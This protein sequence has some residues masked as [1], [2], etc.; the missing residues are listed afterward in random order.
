MMDTTGLTSPIHLR[1]VHYV[2]VTRQVRKPNGEQYENTDRDWSWLHNA[3][4]RAARWLGYVPFDRIV[5]ERNDAPIIRDAATR[6]DPKPTIWLAGAPDFSDFD[7]RKVGPRASLYEEPVSP[8]RYRLAMFGEKTSLDAVLGPLAEEYN[9]DL[10]LA[11]GEQT[12]SGVYGLARDAAADG[13]ELIVFVFADCDPAGWQ[14]AVSIAHKVRAFHDMLFPDLRFRVFAP[15]LTVEQVNTLD[16]PSTPLK[17]SERRANR[18]T[19][20][21]GVEQTEID[22]LAT[23]QPD[24]LERIAR[25]A[26]DPFYDST[27]KQRI[28]KAQTNWQRRAQRRLNA[29]AAREPGYAELRSDAMAALSEAETALAALER[30]TDRF[31]TV[32]LPEFEMPEAE[33]DDDD[34]DEP[35]ISSDM[36]L[37]EHIAALR[38][39]KNYENSE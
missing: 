23:L 4:A 27:L 11:A 3:V 36:D 15:A 18:W 13:R 12:I 31:W 29:A 38:K 14:M 32:D 1:G 24:E 19:E 16:L 22:A 25:L 2:L 21:F 39:R 6:C 28:E 20:A 17:E 5:D 7:A 26:I 9:A 8:Q 34:A 33:P 30:D 10:Y 35:L 37:E